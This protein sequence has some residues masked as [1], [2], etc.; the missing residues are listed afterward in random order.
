MGS[1]AGGPPKLE[2]STV[3]AR[4]P[5]PDT[6]RLAPWTAGSEGNWGHEDA[7][8]VTPWEAVSLRGKDAVLTL[9]FQA[10]SSSGVNG[11]RDPAPRSSSPSARTGLPLGLTLL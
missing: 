11:G 7:S 9:D 6:T 3:G 10:S 4:P 8:P 5:L 1:W 2:K